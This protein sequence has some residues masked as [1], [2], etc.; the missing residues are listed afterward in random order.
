MRW[1]GV[2]WLA[3]HI[4]LQP[5]FDLYQDL[6]DRSRVAVIDL[7][8]ATII[9]DLALEPGIDDIAWAPSIQP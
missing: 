5:T 2:A 7:A 9:G 1:A 4:D 6:L 8:T 3:M